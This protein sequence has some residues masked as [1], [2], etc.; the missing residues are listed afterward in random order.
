M[1]KS[2][3]QREYKTPIELAKE[4]V[5]NLGYRSHK[6]D[7]QVAFALKPLAK[8]VKELEEHSR[9]KENKNL[10]KALRQL[11]DLLHVAYGIAMGLPDADAVADADSYLMTPECALGDISTGLPDL[12][13]LEDPE[14]LVDPEL[15]ALKEQLEDLEHEKLKERE[16]PTPEELDELKKRDALTRLKDLE[17]KKP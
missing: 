14:E 4:Y 1:K 12:E 9:N 10:T 15:A 13:G 5:G 8:I 3:R 11:A 2:R 16:K 7:L 6:C 17:R